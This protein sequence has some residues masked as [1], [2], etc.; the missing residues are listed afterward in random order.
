[1]IYIEN[2]IRLHSN[3]AIGSIEKRFRLLC[4]FDRPNSE[5]MNTICYVLR[6]M[7]D[8]KTFIVSMLQLFP[9]K[10]KRNRL[11]ME[12]IRCTLVSLQSASIKRDHNQWSRWPKHFCH[13]QMINLVNKRH[14]NYK[15]I[16]RKSSHLIYPFFLF[17]NWSV[18]SGRDLFIRSSKKPMESISNECSWQFSSFIQVSY[19]FLGLFHF[20]SIK[21]HSQH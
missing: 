2:F 21:N 3:S 18:R 16:N 19:R 17:I 10:N 9:K 6:A 14:E 13:S 1:M 11:M 12:I 20:G 8:N 7:D 15:I 5:Q 4:R